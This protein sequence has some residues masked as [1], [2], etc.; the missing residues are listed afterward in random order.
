LKPKLL[1]MGLRCKEQMLVMIFSCRG[2]YEITKKF[3]ISLHQGF[4]ARKKIRKK[5]ISC[6]L[7]IIWL[8]TDTHTNK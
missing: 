3:V 4:I 6:S 8:Y 7:I 1:F 5:K 2:Y